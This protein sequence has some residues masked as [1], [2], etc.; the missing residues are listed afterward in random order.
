M[1]LRRSFLK[2]YSE[3]CKK[4]PDTGDAEIWFGVND[5]HYGLFVTP[6]WNGDSWENDVSEI[7]AVR[8]KYW[9][10]GH[11]MHTGLCIP[12]EDDTYQ[13]SKKEDYLA[14]LK[15]QARLT[16]SQYQIDIVDRY[17]KFVESSENPMDIPLLIPE[18]RYDGSG[19]KHKHRLD[20]LIINPFTME[21]VGF[22]ISP[23]SSHGKLSG[24]HKTMIELNE[25]ALANFEA[26]VQKARAYFKKYKIPVLH[27]TDSDLTDLEGVFNHICTYLDPGI[28]PKQMEM[29]LFSEYFGDC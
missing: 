15:A 8:F 10:I 2:H 23:W 3:L 17:I 26:E 9:T 21:K 11:I 28:P 22:E 25:E 13:F 4:R 7:R 6:R 5:A 12:D 19:K 20:F 27:F 29:G 18:L 24:K 1:F 16:K 14:F